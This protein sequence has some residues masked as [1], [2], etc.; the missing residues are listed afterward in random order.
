[1]P[2]LDDDLKKLHEKRDYYRE[3]LRRLNM[4]DE[5]AVEVKRQLEVTEWQIEA[6]ESAPPEASEIPK[7]NLSKT[8]DSDIANM[9]IT[10]PFV[11]L[12]TKPAGLSASAF[13]STGTVSVYEYAARVGDLG[14][15]DAIEYSQRTTVELRQLQQRQ[16]RPAQV[17]QLISR[18][19]SASTVDRLEAC[20]RSY[21]SYSAGRGNRTAPAT[22]IRTLIEGVRGDLFER[23][24][25]HPNENMTW[26]TMAPRLAIDGE[27]GAHC[28]EI[29]RLESVSSSLISRL[30]DIIHDREAGSLTNVH[31]VWAETQDF[32]VALLGH[33]RTD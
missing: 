20:L 26:P 13:S 30:S 24:R 28:Q 5:A 10:Y 33:V 21:A 31:N 4:A 6:L 12:Y 8:L 29:L 17:R 23:A 3:W 19:C 9:K 22:D 32:L 18:T 14:T 7:P 2:Q 15:P 1:M 11:P 27:D 16:D 25:M